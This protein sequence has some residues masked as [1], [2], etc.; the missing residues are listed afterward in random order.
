MKASISEAFITPKNS[1]FR[2]NKSSDS[3]MLIQ[4]GVD[5]VHV[6]TFARMLKQSP[7]LIDKIFLNSEQTFSLA[8]LAANFAAK[9]A[10]IKACGQI[11]INLNFLDIQIRREFNGA[12]YVHSEN[13]LLESIEL[14]ISMSHHNKFA[15][16]FAVAWKQFG[17]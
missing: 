4:I 6:P 7:N 2:E 8:S 12:P 9:E 10:I 13:D 17:H 1:L 5:L 14:R 3:P 16:A 11:N 15:I